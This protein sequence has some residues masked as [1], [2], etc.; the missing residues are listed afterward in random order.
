MWLVV[1]VPIDLKLVAVR[2]ADK[3]CKWRAKGRCDQAVDRG[4]LGLTRHCRS[5][6]I[7][8]NQVGCR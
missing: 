8:L 7:S 6:S 2:Q 5:R 1:G 4:S 3:P